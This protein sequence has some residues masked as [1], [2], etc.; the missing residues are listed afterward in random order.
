MSRW[1]AALG[2]EILPDDGL[3]RGD[4]LVAGLM[5]SLEIGDDHVRH[6]PECGDVDLET[7][8][9]IQMKLGCRLI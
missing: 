5:E 1:D 2:Y 8:L 4:E 6:P 9:L 7:V 3:W